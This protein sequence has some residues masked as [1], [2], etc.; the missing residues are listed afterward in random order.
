MQNYHVMTWWEMQTVEWMSYSGSSHFS[1]QLSYKILF[2]L[3]CGWKDMNYARFKYLQEFLEKKIIEAGP[4]LS[5]SATGTICRARATAENEAAGPR[6]IRSSGSEE[7]K[8]GIK[9]RLLGI[10]LMICCWRARAPTS[11]ATKWRWNIWDVLGFEEI[12]QGVC[13]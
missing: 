12:F 6:P 10:E 13:F 4:D 8:D 9:S 1:E 11:W 5:P 2:I 7:Q 3:S